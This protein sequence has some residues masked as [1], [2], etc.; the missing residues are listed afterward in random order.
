VRAY[1]RALDA[2]RFAL[3]W[4]RLSPGVRAAFGGFTAWRAGYSSTVTSRPGPVTILSRTPAAVRLR[5]RLDAVDRSPCR[6]SRF[7]V[8]WSLVRSAGD[9]RAQSLSA[10]AVS[11]AEC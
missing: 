3:A 10:I 5:H 9:W 4:R 6:R 8:D 2:R 7:T 11:A 1:Y